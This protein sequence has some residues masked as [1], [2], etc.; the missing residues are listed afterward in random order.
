MLTEEQK[1]N[2]ARV[3]DANA[4]K[5]LSLEKVLNTTKQAMSTDMLT[6]SWAEDVIGADR[7]PTR[8]H[9]REVFNQFMPH[10]VENG[11]D[12][13]IVCDLIKVKKP[14]D[15]LSKTIR[16]YRASVDSEIVKLD[17]CANCIELS[18]EKQA[19][20]TKTVKLDSGYEMDVELDSFDKEGKPIME[21]V[22]TQYVPRK[23]SAW[24]YTKDVKTALIKAIEF[25]EE[26]MTAPK[27][28]QENV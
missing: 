8:K 11:T 9:F 23:K 10:Y 21:T 25:I 19:K 3:F 4:D 20:E 17:V 27:S 12:E 6:K 18:E 28:A 14:E 13:V 7:T 5:Q 1:K 2:I 24:G 22:K 16:Q 26:E 15:L